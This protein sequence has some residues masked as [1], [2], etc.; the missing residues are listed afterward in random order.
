MAKSRRRAPVPDGATPCL[1]QHVG[2]N[3]IILARL[4]LE[5]NGSSVVDREHRGFKPSGSDLILC[6]FDTV[7]FSLSHATCATV[8]QNMGVINFQTSD[9]EANFL[10]LKVTG[11]L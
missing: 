8:F 1:N 11:V 2:S 10:C 4:E 9:M 3:F 6:Q 7:L 5:T